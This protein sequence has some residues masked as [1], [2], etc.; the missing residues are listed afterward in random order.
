[1]YGMLSARSASTS[2]IEKIQIKK[3]PNTPYFMAFLWLWNA[4]KI[5]LH[6]TTPQ[7]ESKPPLLEICKSRKSITSHFTAF[8]RL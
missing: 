5:N 7:S 1:M 2:T 6:K 8:L 4:L 3:K